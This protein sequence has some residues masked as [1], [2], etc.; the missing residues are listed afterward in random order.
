MVYIKLNSVGKNPEIN[1]YLVLSIEM[2]YG[3]NCNLF[4]FLVLNIAQD[5]SLIL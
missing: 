4:L 3:R 1:K 5:L 2:H